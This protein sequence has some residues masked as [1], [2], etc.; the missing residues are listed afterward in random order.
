MFAKLGD[1]PFC[2]GRVEHEPSVYE[3]PSPEVVDE[4]ALTFEVKDP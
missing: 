4:K 2:I 1:V 3:L